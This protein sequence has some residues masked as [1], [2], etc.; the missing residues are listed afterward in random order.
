MIIMAFDVVIL[1]IP[2]PFPNTT[3]HTSPPLFRRNQIFGRATKMR[4]SRSESW[5]KRLI[6]SVTI[7]TTSLQ[8]KHG[9]E[10]PKSSLTRLRNVNK[11]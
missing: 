11:Y 7:A 9:Q 8:R 5:G 3:I 4:Q 2:I 1:N 10:M 6:L